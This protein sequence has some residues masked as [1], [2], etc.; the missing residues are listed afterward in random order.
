MLLTNYDSIIH[1][2]VIPDMIATP[3]CGMSYSVRKNN[4]SGLY[5]GMPY[6]AV[7]IFNV[8]HT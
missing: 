4:Q 3:C 5:I 6:S 7:E 2:S 8:F 1:A